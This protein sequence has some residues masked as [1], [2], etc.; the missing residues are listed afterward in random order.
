MEP[1]KILIFNRFKILSILFA[2][3]ALSMLLLMIRMKL[4]QSFHFL[5]LVW[6]LFL[7]LIPFAITTALASGKKPYK[8]YFLVVFLV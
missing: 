1:L 6:N 2:A 3:M 4:N 8:L 5:F 7:A